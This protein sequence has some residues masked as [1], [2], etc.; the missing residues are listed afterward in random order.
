MDYFYP[1]KQRR[2]LFFS[3]FFTFSDFFT[4]T[5]HVSFKNRITSELYIVK[6]TVQEP[7]SNPDPSEINGKTHTNFSQAGFHPMLL[8]S[9]FGVP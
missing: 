3:E 9:D 6:N 8:W 5:S 4:F 7:Q 2:V 1:G